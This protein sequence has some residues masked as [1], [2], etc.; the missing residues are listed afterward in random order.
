MVESIPAVNTKDKYWH[1]RKP[2]KKPLTI[3]TA[4]PY[5]ELI[6]DGRSAGKF[7]LVKLDRRTKLAALLEG[8]RKR[9]LEQVGPNPT[10]IQRTLID[11]AAILSL[12][13]A[14]TD[15]WILEDRELSI[16]DNNQI[17]AWQNAL[18]RVL[19]ALGV[20]RNTSKPTPSLTEIMAE[21]ND[22]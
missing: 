3:E 19:V 14:Q 16:L 8:V 22:E 20:N 5:S 2:R 9:L 12:R 7:G 4:S 15:R 11:R 21:A 18:T 17:I 13:L 6:Y 10:V 1:T